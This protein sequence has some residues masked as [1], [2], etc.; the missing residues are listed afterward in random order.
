MGYFCLGHD[1]LGVRKSLRIELGA[2][3]LHSRASEK[4]SSRK[5]IYIIVDRS[6]SKVLRTLRFRRPA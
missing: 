5:L 2:G 6:G 4:R 1:I 3:Y